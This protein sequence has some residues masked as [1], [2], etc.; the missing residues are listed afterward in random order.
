M[1][2]CIQFRAE[3]EHARAA[4]IKRWLEQSGPMYR[5]QEYIKGYESPDL[6]LSYASSFIV[7][8]AL[9]GQRVTVKVRTV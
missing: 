2:D 9:C 5:E 3:I 1:K 4:E 8:W 7:V 6:R